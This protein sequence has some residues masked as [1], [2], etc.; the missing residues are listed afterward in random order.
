[1]EKFKK[2]SIPVVRHLDDIDDLLK[3]G[4]DGDLLPGQDN[5]AKDFAQDILKTAKYENK[6]F[7]RCFFKNIF[8][9]VNYIVN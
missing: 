6:N 5:I 7:Y 9:N 1:M 2:T 3:F 8:F 4:R